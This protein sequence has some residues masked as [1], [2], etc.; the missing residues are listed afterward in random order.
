MHVI[1][2][3]P[4]KDGVPAV[5]S[6]SPY[7]RPDESADDALAR[8]MVELRS[9]VKRHVA[10]L[11][12]ARSDAH[13]QKFR[14]DREQ[15]RADDLVKD[16]RRE[17]KRRKLVDLAVALVVASS[18]APLSWCFYATFRQGLGLTIAAMVAW[19]LFWRIR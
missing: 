2:K 9:A 10:A 3:K 19:L 11:R 6:A 18:A 12:E 13:D 14:A 8:E 15:A 5:A 1:E 4:K 17:R 16:L 7:R